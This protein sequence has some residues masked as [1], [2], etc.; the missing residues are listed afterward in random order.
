MLTTMTHEVV[1]AAPAELALLC[2]ETWPHA[3]VFLAPDGSTV[4]WMNSTTERF[5][6]EHG[7]TVSGQRILLAQRERQGDLEEFLSTASDEAQSWALNLPGDSDALIFRCRTIG[8]TGYRVLTIFH[9]QNPPTVVP[10][11]RLLFGLTP[12]EARILHGLVDG[13]RADDLADDLSVSIE[14]IR[15]H[16]RRIYNKLEVN[17]REQLIAKVCLYRVP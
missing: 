7:A 9:P 16:I 6:K 11:V 5:L 12:S 15:T 4:F 1:P 17:S 3:V 13:R 2:I 8:E 10:D 14:T